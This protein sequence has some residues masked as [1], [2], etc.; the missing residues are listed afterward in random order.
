MDNHGKDLSTG[1]PVSHPDFVP[2]PTNPAEAEVVRLAFFSS[3]D[4]IQS[5]DHPQKP[6]SQTGLQG[7]KDFDPAATN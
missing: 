5:G 6:V 7:L 4:L 2:F 1:L 3:F